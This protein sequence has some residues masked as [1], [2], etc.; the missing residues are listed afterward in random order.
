MERRACDWSER[1]ERERGKGE[2]GR[3]RERERDSWMST[4]E[5]DSRK[6]MKKLMPPRNLVERPKRRRRRKCCWAKKWNKRLKQISSNSGTGR[7]LSQPKLALE[8]SPSVKK[9]GVLII[10]FRAHEA[11]LCIG[12]HLKSHLPGPFICTLPPFES[13]VTF[14]QRPQ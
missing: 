8:K 3:E 4:I 10:L 1:G 6:K 11:W 9:E 12:M 5:L 7:K 14:R 2:G 13:L